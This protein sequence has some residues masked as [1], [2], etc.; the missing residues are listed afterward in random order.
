[1]GHMDF[2]KWDELKQKYIIELKTVRELAEEYKGQISDTRIGQISSREKWLEQRKQ[3]WQ[4]IEQDFTERMKNK[5][6]KAKE[7][8]FDTGQ[9]VLARGLEILSK[10]DAKIDERLAKDLIDLGNKLILQSGGQ[11]MTETNI[12][13]RTLILNMTAS[14]ED[15]IEF[16]KFKE[17][18]E[19]D[20]LSKPAIDIAKGK[21]DKVDNRQ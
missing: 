16:I 15:I 6:I 11:A 19:K 21:P 17:K 10:K 14:Q 7:R 8:M 13:A 5:I 3:Y 2:K 20:E 18:K 1:M 12:D 4:E 9:Y